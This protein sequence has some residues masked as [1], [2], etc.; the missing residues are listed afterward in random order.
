M[1]PRPGGAAFRRIPSDLTRA[2][3]GDISHATPRPGCTESVKNCSASAGTLIVRFMYGPGVE[4]VWARYWAVIH[5]PPA[6]KA[7]WA[8]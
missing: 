5:S 4:S 2:G 8:I 3:E 7:G 6:A 1:R